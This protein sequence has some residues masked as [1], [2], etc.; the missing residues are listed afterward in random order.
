MPDCLRISKASDKKENLKGQG[1]IEVYI[2]P[3]GR[4]RFIPLT[5]NAA[6][7]IRGFL[8]DSEKPPSVYCG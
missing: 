3:G 7:A 4:L 1:C 2:E 5:G 8:K 6:P